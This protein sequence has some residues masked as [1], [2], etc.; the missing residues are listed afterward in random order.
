MPP[1]P[2]PEPAPEAA[3]VRRHAGRAFAAGGIGLLLVGGAAGL[4]WA[5]TALLDAGGFFAGASA[6]L[7]AALAVGV[8]AL[9]LAALLF[10]LLR[11]VERGRQQLARLDT[12]DTLTGVANRAHF[13]ALAER[14]WARARRYGGEPALLLIEVD[15]FQR[16]VDSRGSGAGD[17]VLREIVKSVSP[18]LRGADALARFGGSQLAVWLAQADPIGALDVADRIRERVEALEIGAAPPPAL[19]VT[20]SVGVAALRAAHTN[21]GALTAD[22]EAAA[23]S[24]RQAGGNCVR[25]A[26]VDAGRSRRIGPSVGDNQAAGPM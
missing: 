17:T 21:L 11:E 9:P 10:K 20:V 16:L 12:V 25:A 24:A 5:L 7:A 1:A 13:L 8:V 26:P 3:P 6:P 18:T 14:E 22:A 23:H 2:T 15:R 4:A 19:R